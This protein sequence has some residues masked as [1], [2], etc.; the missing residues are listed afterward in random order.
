MSLYRIVFEKTF[1]LPSELENRTYWAI[2]KL[3]FNAKAFGEKKV[4]TYE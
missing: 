3:N 2:W 1:H 4:I